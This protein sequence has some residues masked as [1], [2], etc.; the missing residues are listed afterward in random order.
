MPQVININDDDI[1][2]A[3]SI[4]LPPGK[5][6][7][8][9]RRTFI[10]N[11]D[12][13]DL[14]A[15][16]GSGK[17]TALLAKLLIFERK[18]P[19]ENG[20]GIL[21]LSHTNAAI[22]EIKQKIQKHCPK[23][24][25]YPNFIG[26]IQSFVDEFLAIPYYTAI[27]KKKTTRIDNEI[28]YE[29]I[30]KFVSRNLP[31]FTVQEQRNARYFLLGTDSLNSFRLQIRNGQTTLVESISGNDLRII[32]PRRGRNYVDFTDPEKQRVKEWLT[33][34]KYAL[35]KKTGVLHFD[36]AYFLAEAYLKNIP[37]MKDLLQKRFNYVFVDEMQ[38]MDKHQYDVLEKIFYDVNR[39]ISKYQR[40]GDKNQSIFNGDI[41]LENIWNDRA[42][43]LTINGSQRLTPLLA[44]L[45]NK[46]ALHR[47]QGF[48][49][50]GLRDGT[51][52]PHVIK[53][54]T[55]SIRN[56]IPTF[57]NTIRALQQI[58][59]FPL[60]PQ[61]PIKVVAWNSN[62]KTQAERD[63]PTKVRLID[64]FSEYNKEDHSKTIDY[65]CLKSYLY[66]F[67]KNKRTLDPIRKCLLNALLKILRLEEVFDVDSRNYTRK[68][69]VDTIKDCSH[70]QDDNNYT[71]FQLNLYNWSIDIVRGKLDDVWN[72]IKIY[73]PTF[74]QL[75][76]K[77]V[78]NSR[79]FLDKDIEVGKEALEQNREVSDA[80]T[81]KFDDLYVE[82]TTV[83]AVKGQ[84][85]SA[86]L[87]LESSYYG[88]HESE[89]LNGQFLGQEFA[90]NRERHKQSAKMAYVGLSR[91]TNLICIA[92]HQDRYND[93]F[94]E[95]N[96]DEW[97]I[98]EVAVAPEQ[99]Q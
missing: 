70:T 84:T 13:I 94:R 9:E 30:Q 87:Y 17:T 16:P 71:S 61:Y 38:D 66:S 59:Q 8:E 1:M 97:E 63:N 88:Q 41:K 27:F 14:Q 90:N 42:I 98:I 95:I 56:V 18:L 2:Y 62:W 96:L 55:N 26:T 74:L 15:V 52:K 79:G 50:V 11:L 40:I 58:Q 39:S 54:T 83:H 80:N 64:Y 33:K 93:F 89:R 60:V 86:T 20:S 21:V 91:P 75:F 85:H 43:I 47:T 5:S 78:V 10:K 69:L 46:F 12:T 22:D 53:Y 67:E 3:Q 72:A 7:D 82:I 25:S 81:V 57:L 6:F 29:T 19:F 36:D 37:Q 31:D 73:V 99:A 45:V 23:L 35:M 92:V 51:V 76:G 24:F 48:G 44:N 65:A 49:I 68:R 28:Y 34:F 4:L 32:K 77:Q